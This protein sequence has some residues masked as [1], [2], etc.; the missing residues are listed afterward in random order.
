MDHIIIATNV[1]H[2]PGYQRS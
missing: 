2:R 1:M